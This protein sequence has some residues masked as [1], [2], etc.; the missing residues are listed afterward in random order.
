MRERIALLDGTLDIASSRERGTSVR[1]HVPLAAASANAISNT[2]SSQ[3][4]NH[5][6]W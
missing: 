1:V 2:T 5:H 3:T 4:E 6:A